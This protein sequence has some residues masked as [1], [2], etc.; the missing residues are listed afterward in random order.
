[1]VIKLL[2]KSSKYILGLSGGPDSVFLFNY[3]LDNGFKN[4]VV[5]HVNY[6]FRKDSNQDLELVKK[7]CKKYEI[8]YFIKNI[9]QDYNNLKENFESWA[10]TIR[11]DFFCEQFE[12]QKADAILIAHNLNDHIETYL[13]QKNNK[14]KVRYFGINSESYYKN[15]KILRPIL[16]IKK[17]DIIKDLDEK[18]IGYI[19]D[20]TNSDLKYERNKLRFTLRENTFNK[21]IKEID[22]KNEKILNYKLKIEDL[23]Y[24]NVLNI[25]KFNDDNEWNEYLLFSFL[26]RN[27]FSYFLYK[28]KKAIIRE[29]LKQILSKK[30]LVEIKKGNLILMKDYELIRVVNSEELDTFEIEN[31]NDKFF[32]KLLIENNIVNHEN[33]V[34]TN[35]WKKYQ[36][37]LLVNDKF[38][39]KI[40]RD[41][42]INYL[43]RYKNI[44][45][46]DKTKKILLNKINI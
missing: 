5:C 34:V 15:K 12:K 38:L 46:F 44:L 31:S 35:N 18:N 39:S 22:I 24:S 9:K 7:M 32:K 37:K 26:E 1:M 45:I 20:S 13:M 33:I 16:S 17:S 19:I 14:K 6:N 42:K 2:K 40:Y 10:R 36:S 27:Q 4:F 8:E 11:Y 41:K 29:F 28:T 23:I 21:L 43:K 30:K 25:D 3:L